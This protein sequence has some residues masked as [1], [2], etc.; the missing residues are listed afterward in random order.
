MSV[1]EYVAA[2]VA[3]VMGLSVA[4]VMGGVGAFI[5]TKSRTSTDWLV[6]GWCIALIVTQI[7]W[8]MLGWFTVGQLGASNR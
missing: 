2:F 5:L 3:I 8:W 1:F 4:R 6:F 7:G